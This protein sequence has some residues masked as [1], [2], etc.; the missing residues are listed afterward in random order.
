MTDPRHISNFPFTS[1]VE[2]NDQISIRVLTADD[3]K[4][5]KMSS[6]KSKSHF[7]SPYRLLSYKHKKASIASVF[8]WP[9]MIKII[10]G[11]NAI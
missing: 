1:I 9:V 3:Q 10:L 4:V 2:I 8:M 5:K 11:L 6:L 7:E